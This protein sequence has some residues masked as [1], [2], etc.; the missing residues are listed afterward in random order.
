[1]DAYRAQ[2]RQRRLWY[3]VPKCRTCRNRGGKCV[4]K[5]DQ[6]GCELACGFCIVSGQALRCTARDGALAERQRR[7]DFLAIAQ[8]GVIDLV[9]S[10]EDG[11][12]DKDHEINENDEDD[13]K[14]KDEHKHDDGSEFNEEIDGE[15]IL[16]D[17]VAVRTIVEAVDVEEVVEPEQAAS[18]ELCE[19][20]RETVTLASTGQD[21]SN[22]TFIADKLP[23]PQ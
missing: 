6:R 1:M 3:A 18:I 17:S 10:D 12:G 20:D 4:V 2:Q 8:G 13:A 11:T 14:H 15:E 16:S 21:I 7:D 22:S 9:S 19:I 23:Q 5:L